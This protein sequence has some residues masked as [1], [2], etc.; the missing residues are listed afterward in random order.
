[1]YVCMGEYK[2]GKED[3]W[4]TPV[5]IFVDTVICMHVYAPDGCPKFVNKICALHSCNICMYVYMCVHIF[6]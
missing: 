1:M 3:A 5:S 6:I 4:Q 2:P